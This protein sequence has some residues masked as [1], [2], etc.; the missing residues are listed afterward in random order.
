MIIK[1]KKALWASIGA[2]AAM[3]LLL[4][5]CLS[6]P[7]KDRISP[8][9]SYNNPTRLYLNTVG[10][11]YNYIGGNRAHIEVFTIIIPLHV[12]KQLYLLEA[13]IGMMEAFGS[14]FLHNN[15]PKKIANFMPLGVISTKWLC[16]AINRLRL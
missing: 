4:S 3:S 9:D 12:T 1:K 15:G 7:M 10:T 2:T 13:E 6:E 16:S 11:L 5:S 14:V 8:E